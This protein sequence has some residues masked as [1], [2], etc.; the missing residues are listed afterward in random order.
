MLQIKDY[1]DFH[2]FVVDKAKNRA[3]EVD[4]LV[5]GYDCLDVEDKVIIINKCK[6]SFYDNYTRVGDSVMLKEKKN[7]IK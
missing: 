4:E 2:S 3:I 6:K 7:D 5:L 1:N